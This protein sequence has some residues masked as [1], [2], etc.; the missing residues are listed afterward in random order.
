MVDNLSVIGKDMGLYDIPTWST[1]DLTKMKVLDIGQTGQLVY[2]KYGNEGAIKA[3]FSTRPTDATSDMVFKF[4]SEYYTKLPTTEAILL[5]SKNLDI[6]LYRLY[7]DVNGSPYFDIVPVSIFWKPLSK[8]AYDIR[9]DNELA[10]IESGGRLYSLTYGYR[11]LASVWAVIESEVV[12]KP[13][14]VLSDA[15]LTLE[16]IAFL[17]GYAVGKMGS[18]SVLPYNE[19]GY[20]NTIA[21]FGACSSLLDLKQYTL[22][23]KELEVMIADEDEEDV[24]VLDYKPTTYAPPLLPPAY[25]NYLPL[26]EEDGKKEV[27]TLSSLLSDQNKSFPIT[28]TVEDLGLITLAKD[29]LYK[30]DNP[31]KFLGQNQES[32]GIDVCYVYNDTAYI[33]DPG[34]S[35]FNNL[36]ELDMTSMTDEEEADYIEGCMI[37]YYELEVVQYITIGS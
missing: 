18:P 6:V 31:R 21:Y 2:V 3:Y 33:S 23:T 4:A 12:Y 30:I 17:D 22:D 9:K 16:G 19:W 36:G 14:S 32:L 29:A 28:I 13:I 25:S 7:H 15:N 35:V 24:I 8:K 37:D 5:D 27:P 26:F 20:T 10:I 1:I 11:G 34:D